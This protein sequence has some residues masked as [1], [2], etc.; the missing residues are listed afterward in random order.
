MKQRTVIKL[1]ILAVAAILVYTQLTIF[2]IPP[3]GI[4]PTGKTLIM[5]RL[6]TTKFIDSPDAMCERTQGGVSLFCRAMTMGAVME[7]GHIITQLPYSS[8]LY[9]ISTDGKHYDR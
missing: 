4:L 5:T 1:V 9:E 8:W 3:M 7:K 2:V 6:N